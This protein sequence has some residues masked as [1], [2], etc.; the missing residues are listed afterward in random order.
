MAAQVSLRKYIVSNRLNNHQMKT[1]GL[2]IGGLNR[3]LKEN[4]TKSWWFLPQ[5]PHVRAD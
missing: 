1:G 4:T 2:N 5:L 3:R